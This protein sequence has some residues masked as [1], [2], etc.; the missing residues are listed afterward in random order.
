M[1][2]TCQHSFNLSVNW[3]AEKIERIFTKILFV[4]PS[5]GSEG[6]SNVAKVAF[7]FELFEYSF[8]QKWSDIELFGFVI[9]KFNFKPVVWHRLSEFN[10]RVHISPISMGQF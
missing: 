5:H 8:I 6:D 9:R 4:W 3:C 7:V 10:C 1:S 2:L